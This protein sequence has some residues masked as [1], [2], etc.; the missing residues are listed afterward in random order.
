MHL[1]FQCVRVQAP[2]A[3]Q[4][5]RE[6]LQH[7]LTFSYTLRNI[8]VDGNPIETDQRV[9]LHDIV[10]NNDE[11]MQRMH[12]AALFDFLVHL[13]TTPPTGFARM[14][15]LLGKNDP[16]GAFRN[17]EHERMQALFARHAAAE[18]GR[19]RT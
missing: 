3:G 8:G 9:S 10:N 13:Y 18:V 7:R 17:A 6:N 4:N 14:H 12:C 5:P 1:G 16:L 15:A 19:H 11:A 2:V